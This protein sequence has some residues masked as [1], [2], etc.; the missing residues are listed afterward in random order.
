MEFAHLVC[1]GG[2]S[3]G[4]ASVGQYF[5]AVRECAADEGFWWNA[6]WLTGGSGLALLALV[7]AVG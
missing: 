4:A 5:R 2:I 7:V 6:I 1:V 3:L